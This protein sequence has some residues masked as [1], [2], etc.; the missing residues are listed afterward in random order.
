M[1]EKWEATKWVF[2]FIGVMLLV[3]LVGY[4][5]WPLSKRVEREVL[6]NSHQYIEGMQDRAAIL[7]ASLAEIDARLA[8]VHDEQLRENLLNQRSAIQAQLVAIRRVR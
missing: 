3:T 6:I 4:V 5:L 8:T 1:N 7:Q 2:W